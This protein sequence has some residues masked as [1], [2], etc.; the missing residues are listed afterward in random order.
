MPRTV[1]KL[2]AIA[3]LSMILPS[4]GAAAP[5]VIE[6]QAERQATSGVVI[7]PDRTF[8]TVAAEASGRQ[9]VQL[10]APGQSIEIKLLAPANALTIRYS[11]SRS[12]TGA[13][14]PS[15]LTLLA[16][17]QALETEVLTSRYAFDL[18]PL[19]PH[20]G[21]SGPLHH[22]WDEI[23]VKLAHRLAAGTILSLQM[24]PASNPFA[25]DLVDAEQV[26]PPAAAP[27][28]ALS[29][30]MFGADR[31]GTRDSASAFTQAAA[32]AERS[33][34]VLYVPPGRYHVDGHIELDHV[35]VVGA[36]SWY[37]V[38]TG[39][40][41]GFYSR[42]TGS[43]RVSLQELAIESDVSD[44]RDVL[45]LA[46]VGGTFSHSSFRNLYL[47]HA[48]VGIWLDGPARDLTIRDV[49][50][51]DQTA[52]GINL[53]R[54]IRDVRVEDNRVR[55]TGDDGIASWS[56]GIANSNVLIRGNRISA[57]SLANG[58]SIYGG[59]DI[60]VD[61]NDIADVLIEGG[62]IHLGARFRS[63]P[64][65]GRIRISRNR[66]VRSGAFDP[67]WH[68]GIGAIWLYALERPINSDI[69][70]RDNQIVEPGCE[71]FQLL[72]PKRIDGVRIDG[73]RIRSGSP[74]LFAIQTAGAMHA[75]R[76][77]DDV[78]WPIMVRVPNDFRFTAGRG[79]RGWRAGAA[80][81]HQS[82][83]CI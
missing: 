49:E 62:G 74:S 4:V 24:A 27:S 11:L 42:P 41:L 70:F 82:P 58:I 9:A 20:A 17:G 15:S 80:A 81:G 31:S 37:S 57:P 64:F 38:V 29:V 75:S 54:G 22:F 45:P 67:N 46:A 28:G 2:G 66:I 61:H 26:P 71:A 39:H 47:H 25:V 73:L 63:T 69:L 5:A 7:P 35:R 78:T 18:T 44:R 19:P 13:R 32:T 56:E 6:Y 1:R 23:R 53:H 21:P 65:N 50:I 76:V 55:N 60:D 68:F 40:Q 12:A 72:G 34:R 83:Q 10:E 79:D 59:T 52:D 51:A 14:L 77:L 8:G 48:K 3:F 43:S 16:N 33:G 36:G 30:L